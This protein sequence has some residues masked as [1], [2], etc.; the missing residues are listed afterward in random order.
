[1][2]STPADATREQVKAFQAAFDASP[3][4]VGKWKVDP[5]TLM[6]TYG[7]TTWLYGSFSPS[8]FEA[9]PV[10]ALARYSTQTGV[11]GV[12]LDSFGSAEVGCNTAPKPVRDAFKLGC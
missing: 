3:D 11:K 1:V 7:D 12:A 6:L 8:G 10:T 2:A 4:K 9:D 5:G